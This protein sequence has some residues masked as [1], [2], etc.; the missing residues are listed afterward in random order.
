MLTP[1]PTTDGSNV[2]WGLLGRH[3]DQLSELGS[4]QAAL[5]R[6]ATLVARAA[7]PTEVFMAVAEEVGLVFPAD[8]TF[9][10]RYDG[11]A[12]TVVGCWSRRGRPICFGKKIRLGGRN[13]TTVVVRTGRPARQDSF[14][15]ATGDYAEHVRREGFRS[16]FGVPITVG[17]R[18]WGLMT[19]LSRTEIPL[20][21]EEPLADFMELLGCAIANAVAATELLASRA[22]VIV[23]ADEARRRLQRDLHDGA[24][25]RFVSLALRLRAAQAAVP[26]GLDELAADLGEISA[27]L[28]AALDDLR[29]LAGGIHPA[30]LV[31]EGLG[32]ALRA[33][34]H[35]S[36][37]PVGLTVA[38]GDHLPEPVEVA[39]YY[40]VS[41]ALTNAA[42][43]AS[44]SNIAV[45]VE[46]ENG[47]LRVSVSDNGIGGADMTLGSG[48]LGLKDRV[49]SLGGW[50]ALRSEPGAGTSLSVELPF[51]TTTIGH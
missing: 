14:A 8:A 28:T 36:V 43:H 49:E 35:R 46:A 21:C 6:I 4:Q 17:G 31:E 27:E 16:G 33:L 18:L 25:Q 40:V 26:P 51:E 30:I 5:R 9:I 44:A 24:Q 15:D 34:A 7:P 47:V 13:L 50:I 10:G 12:V 19:V 1:E 38:V 20:S 23:S 3:R 41:E 2:M 11:D 45:D 39:A 48:L 32:A 42:K 37:V 22:R 29:Q